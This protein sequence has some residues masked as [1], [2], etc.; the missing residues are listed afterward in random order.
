MT[1]RNRF[2]LASSAIALVTLSGAFGAVC[3]EFTIHQQRYRDAALLMEASDD[4]I[5]A[6]YANDWVTGE[7]FTAPAGELGPVTRY[8]T[9]YDASARPLAWTRNL[10]QARPALSVIRHAPG[11]P[12][13]LWWNG[14]HL[15]AVLVAVPQAGGEFWLATPRTDLD[16]NG[17][18]LA[19][20]MALAVAIAVTAA[21]AAAAW[22]AR[23]LTR[24]HE[25][26]A[27]VARAV[28][29]GDLSARV[30]PLSSGQ[31]TVQ[32]GRDLDEM[33]S[34]LSALVESQRRFIASASHEL[35]S[36]LTT[37]LGEL[38]LSLKRPRDATAY[39]AAIE[40]ALHSTRRLKV[41]TEDLLTLA[42]VR[43]S[44]VELETVSLA[45]VTSAAFESSRVAAET[46]GVTMEASSDGAVVRGCARDL[47]RLMRNLIENAVRHCPPGGHVR[48][49]TSGGSNGARIIVSDEGPGVPPHAR[50]R[51]FEPFF[52]LDAGRSDDA[53][54]GLGLAI[55]RTIARAHGGDLW[56]DCA[57]DGGGARFV[58]TLPASGPPRRSSEVSGE[59]RG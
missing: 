9:I 31:D 40:E 3:L 26:M 56:V 52:R 13:D 11:V 54:A 6:S 19:R 10:E 23:V 30:G 50:E 44:D 18:S 53:G 7:R 2:I 21:A 15:R 55:G 32:L 46:G 41:L 17:A 20:A 58:L 1:L 48:V 39:R 28:A 29:A 38:S 57:S 12:F 22:M 8:A 59:S 34:R 45:Q 42:R 27:T 51:I 33:I 43:E 36:P 5:H 16:A 35:R 47:E 24:D 14:E 49:E 37:L 25:R 4:A